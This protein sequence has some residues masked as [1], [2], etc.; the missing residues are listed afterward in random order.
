MLSL[1]Q[2]VKEMKELAKT[3]IPH[4]FPKVDTPDDQDIIILR[5]RQLL[6]DG[7]DV[8]VAFCISEYEEEN[9]ELQ[10]LQIQGLY[11]PFLPFSLVCKIARLFL[12]SES[13]SYM[14]FVRE[15]RKIYCWTTRWQEGKL[16][17]LTKEVNADS[18]EG[19]TY[20]VLKLGN[21]N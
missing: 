16:A 13:L 2:H 3:L 18:Y 20:N 19:F 21:S 1:E 4:S 7:Y 15:N 8:V 10:S 17:P 11:T 14:H 6:V 5:T 9:Y 12:G